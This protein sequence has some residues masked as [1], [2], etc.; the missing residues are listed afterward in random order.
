MD[1]PSKTI[2][3]AGFYLVLLFSFCV[4]TFPGL[5]FYLAAA[6][7][8]IWFL[9]LLIFKNSDLTSLELF[10]PIGGFVVFSI[11]SWALSPDGSAIPYIGILSFFYIVVQRFVPFAEKRKMI[12][13]TF[14]SG[15]VLSSGIDLVSRLANAHFESLSAQ[16]A[17]ENLSFLIVLVFCLILAMY[18]EGQS[19]R[20]KAFFGL[21]SLPLAA[22]VLF[23]FNKIAVLLLLIIILAIG[24]FKDRTLFIPFGVAVLILISDIFGIREAMNI[25]DYLDYAQSPIQ[26]I[27]NNQELIGV[28]GFY[29]FGVDPALENIDWQGLNSFFIALIKN[30]GPPAIILLF[31]IL[32]GQTRRDFV[33]FRKTAQREIKAYHFGLLLA[34]LVVIVM[35]MYGS[36]LDAPS[37]VMAFWMLLGMSEI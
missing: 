34:M 30:S 37:S 27:W 14:I 16:A 6:V 12:V 7:T 26:E 1:R 2:S 28:A 25:K 19:S 32:F 23:S 20:E 3:N 31:W 15:V 24:I 4:S 18:V 10:Y 8:G 36:T 17:P 29:G 5:A 11:I 13:W 33:K 21:V 35:N 9:E 22:V